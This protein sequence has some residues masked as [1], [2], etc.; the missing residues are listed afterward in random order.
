MRASAAMRSRATVLVVD[1]DPLMRDTTERI[2]TNAHYR[3]VSAASVD[4]ARSVWSSHHPEIALVDLELGGEPGSAL[5]DEPWVRRLDTAVVVL[6]GS[7]DVD[8]ANESFDHGASGYVVK[9]F[10]PNEL[11]MQVSSA[12]RRRDLERT[13]ADHVV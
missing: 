1:D 10:R 3:V 5:L 12:L 13:V 7:D 4:E 11:L 9:P 8:V 6:T 2:L